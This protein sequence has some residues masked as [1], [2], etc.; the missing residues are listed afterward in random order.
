[1]TPALALAERIRARGDTVLVV[2]SERGLESTLV[3]A[4][5]FELA[6]LPSRQLLG[7]SVAARMRMLTGL[8]FV[9]L[10][11]GRTL[12][13]FRAQ[14]VVTVGGYAA[15]PVA[16]AA[17]LLRLPI[18]LVNTDALP[19]QSNRQAARFAHR[20]FVGF[21]GTQ[22]AFARGG[23]PDRVRC[24][25]IP[26]R[27]ALVDAFASAPARRAPAAP[28]R[29]LVFGG[30]QGARQLNQLMIGAVGRLDPTQLEIFHQTGEADRAEVAEAYARRGARAQVVAFEP[31][32]VQ[33]YRWADVALC[34]SGALTVGELALAG[35]PAL[36][37]PYPF[38]AHD[39]QSA[40]AAQLV[41][42]GA[43][44]RLD[45]RTVT[46]EGVAEA[47]SRLFAE[48]HRLSRMG[49]AAAKLARP[50]AAER[51]VE[52]CAALVAPVQGGN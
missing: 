20:I 27:R 45:P 34:R 31:E 48:P 42:A 40:N 28:F 29:L 15:A 7:Q 51:I 11:A 21:E 23:D 50:E 1:V 3:P 33:R 5:G 44:E 17:A 49:L 2:G 36:L 18:A 19:G 22:G 4:A 26:L 12:R 9:V 37:V 6:T 43:A 41:G 52:E 39:E 25:G 14:I 47:L 10:R 35:L 30:S 46:P 13:R 8:P 24:L 32:M 16:A 38:A